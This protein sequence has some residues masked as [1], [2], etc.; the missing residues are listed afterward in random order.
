MRAVPP[1]AINTVGVFADKV[2]EDTQ[3]MD[4]A[5]AV[6]CHLQK[7]DLNGIAGGR[8]GD[9]FKHVKQRLPAVFARLG[10]VDN[11]VAGDILPNFG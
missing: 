2:V 9:I 8:L 4:S 1:L 3:S 6:E 11:L 5:G 10:N 7:A